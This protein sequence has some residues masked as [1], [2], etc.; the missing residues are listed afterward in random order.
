MTKFEEE[1]ARKLYK[2]KKIKQLI[3]KTFELDGNCSDLIV[4]VFKSAIKMGRKENSLKIKNLTKENEELSNSV[5]ELTNTKTELEN[6]VIELETQIENYKLS[7]NEGNEIIT[8]L[9]AQIEKMKCCRNCKHYGN[10]KD[11][12]MCTL[13]GQKI[14]CKN[15]DK[16]E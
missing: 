6:K 10:Y 14:H 5:T 2:T 13:V 12:F 15:K 1:K 9:K 4:E 11:D 7:E 3:F 16:W 8:E